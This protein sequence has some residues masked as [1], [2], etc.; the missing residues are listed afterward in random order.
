[1]KA[2]LYNLTDDSEWEDLGVGFPM[3]E[4]QDR[5]YKFVFYNES[6]DKILYKHVI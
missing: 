4:K 6:S 2:K 1:M 3:I 5:E